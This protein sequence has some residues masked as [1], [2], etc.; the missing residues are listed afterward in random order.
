M[1]PKNLFYVTEKL[2][3]N[4]MWREKMWQKIYFLKTLIFE[5]THKL[6]KKLAF[7]D[8]LESL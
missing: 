3:P 8:I 4:K 1:W 7:Q 6:L 5:I 2:R